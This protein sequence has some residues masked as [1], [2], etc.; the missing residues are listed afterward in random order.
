MKKIA[1]ALT[2]ALAS[3]AAAQA[4]TTEAVVTPVAYQPVAAKPLRFVLGAGLT[5]GG[6]KIATAYYEDGDEIDLRAGDMVA[7]QAG[8]DYRVSP[9]FS[10]KATVGY[11]VDDASARN[12]DMR[13]QRVPFELLGYYHVT[14]KV[15]V[16]GG[17][18][19]VTGAEFRSSGAGDIGDYKFKNT[20][21]AVAE[22][23][24]MATPSIGVTL[25]YVNDEYEEKRYGGKLKG[26]HV[27]AFA[28]FY[29]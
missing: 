12:G 5:F 22:L 26:D 7:V 28:N 13:F 8:I 15:R 24:Y 14:E 3:M 23:E 4:Q 29:F 25:R 1:L 10:L 16:G 17:L 6:D 9:E 27:G 2:L 19:Y 21:S 18:R 20:T 11:H